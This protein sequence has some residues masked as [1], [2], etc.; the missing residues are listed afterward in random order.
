VALEMERLKDP[1]VHV[2]H[3]S[4]PEIIAGEFIQFL[5]TLQSQRNMMVPDPRDLY[6]GH[7]YNNVLCAVEDMFQELFYADR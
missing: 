2:F 5:D 3:G 4:D 1:K 6:M 7:E